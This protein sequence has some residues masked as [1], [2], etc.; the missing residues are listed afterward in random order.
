METL[1]LGSISPF[2]GLLQSTLKKIG[3]YS[4]SIDGVFGNLT[5][6]AVINFQKSFGLIQDGIVGSATW[7]ALFPYIYGYTSYV[8]KRNDTLYNIAVRFSTSVNRIIAANPGINPNNLN[9]G[10]TIIVPFSY[11]VPTDLNY[12]YDIMQMNLSAF[13][14]VYPF[15]EINGIGKT[16]LG[17]E[18]PYLRIGSGKKE[19]FYSAS[20]H[21]NE[22]ITTPVLMKFIENLAKAYV[23]DTYI[24]GYSA[25]SILNSTSIYIVP[26]VNPDGVDLVTNALSENS[27]AYKKAKKIAN[28]Y[29]NIPFPSGWKANIEGV[30][31]KIYQPKPS[32]YLSFKENKHLQSLAVAYLQDF[33]YFCV[34]VYPFYVSFLN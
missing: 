4:G 5:H 28:N 13:T 20:I 21:A 15:I 31:L 10:S 9:I 27:D 6:N 1:K 8:I 26:M 22:W 12:T 16:A 25:R 14:T 23:N 11:I 30:D 24:Y 7:N 3:F 2:V 18:I 33:T 32:A 19:V 29:P 17:K 34:L